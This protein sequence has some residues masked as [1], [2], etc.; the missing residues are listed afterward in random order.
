MHRIL[1]FLF[2]LAVTPQFVSAEE[3][4]ETRLKAAH[5]AGELAGLHSLRVLHDGT[6]LIEIHFPGEDERWG[7]PLG[8][9]EHGP[10]TLHDLR[11][12][13]KS[14]VGVLY[15]IA[16]G[17]GIVAGPDAVLIDQFPEYADLAAD[18]ARRRILVAHALGMQMGIAW[19]ESLPYTDPHNSEIAMWSAPDRIRYVLEQPITEAPGQTWT[20]NGGA[21]AVIARLI[22]NG[23]GQ[24]I[25]AYAA[26]KLFA[27]LEIDRFEWV[28]GPDGT[29]SAASGLRLTADGLSRIGHMVMQG[30][31]YGGKQIVPAAWIET[32]LSPHAQTQWGLRYGYQWYLMAADH[33]SAA[34]WAAGF[35]NGG[36][37][38]SFNRKNRLVAVIF[39]GNYNQDDAWR[40]PVKVIEEFL[41]PEIRRRGL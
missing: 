22:E 1:L 20:Y 23:S 40:L 12:V 28:K 6:E 37:R 19:D 8:Q 10:D 4:L 18:A 31:V 7:S 33:P 29:P 13:T 2:L 15:G 24:P 14:I 26:E 9:R 5:A 30:G 27:P 39:A 16:L 35:G 41:G 34:H 11:S 25:D 32:M 36:Q 21:T 38:V 17:E 3:T